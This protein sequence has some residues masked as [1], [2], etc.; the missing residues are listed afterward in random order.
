M[1]DIFDRTWPEKWHNNY[2]PKAS[3]DSCRYCEYGFIH[4]PT[5]LKRDSSWACNKTSG[6]FLNV[7]PE[8]CGHF[9]RRENDK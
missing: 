3:E 5:L 4:V 2:T 9:R 7:S 8:Y 1:K 6:N